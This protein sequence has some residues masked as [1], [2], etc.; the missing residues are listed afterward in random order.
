LSKSFWYLNCLFG[1]VCGGGQKVMPLREDALS[2]VRARRISLSVVY[3]S[4]A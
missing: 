1:R 2:G 3:K 4:N